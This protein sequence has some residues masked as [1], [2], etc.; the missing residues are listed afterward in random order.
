MSE[1]EALHLPSA[2][3]EK[4]GVEVLRA[5]IIDEGLHV[6]L[7]R[8]FDD[9]STWGVLLADI[10]R[11]VSRVYAKETGASEADVVVDIRRLFDAEL[12]QPTDVGSTDAMN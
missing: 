8:A 2:A 1:F 4:G 9:P 3:F 5:A 11:H 7:K 6:S 12:D 10:A